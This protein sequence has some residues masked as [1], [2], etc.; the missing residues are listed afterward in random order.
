MVMN[1][2]KRILVQTGIPLLILVLVLLFATL[3]RHDFRLT[4]D[5]ALKEVLSPGVVPT[6]APLQQTASD[7]WLLVRLDSTAI[8]KAFASMPA[9]MLQ[10]GMKLSSIKSML[11]RQKNIALLSSDA[12]LSAR[13]WL[14]LVQEGYRHVSILSSDSLVYPK[15]EKLLYNFKPDTSQLE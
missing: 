1:Q 10:P 2:K 7:T 14:W 13:A 8:P 15:G 11:S 4:A 6:E 12:G 5:D 9:I 3:S